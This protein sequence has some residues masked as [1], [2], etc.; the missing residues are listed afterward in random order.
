MEEIEPE[1]VQETTWTDI[2]YNFTQETTWHGVKYVAQPGPVK[3]RKYVLY[4]NLLVAVTIINFK[5]CGQS[6]SPKYV[7]IK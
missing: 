6:N 7:E 4:D 5:T 3:T 2:F 1:R